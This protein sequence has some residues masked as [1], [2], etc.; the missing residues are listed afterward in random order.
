M[1]EEKEDNGTRSQILRTLKG[2]H[3]KNK[4]IIGFDIETYGRENYFYHGGL[5]DDKDGY[6]L[7]YDKEE[8]IK[9]LFK[10]A[11]KT[12]T[13][14]VTATN[15]MFDFTGLFYGSKYW[16]DFQLVMKQGKMLMAKYKDPN[17]HF[18]LAFIDTLN[19]AQFGVKTMGEILGKPKLE[20][21]ACIKNIRYVKNSEGEIE[22]KP[23]GYAR[24]PRD[25]KEKRE[26]E[27]YNRQD[28]I[29]T[30]EFMLFLQE[31]FKS[32]GGKTKL[33]T[34][35]TA[36]DI[37]RRRHLKKWIF[38]EDLILGR[39][40]NNTIH[41]FIFDSYSGG[42]TEVFK[43]GFVKGRLRV[44]DINSMYSEAMLNP[45]PQPDSVKLTNSQN[46]SLL[47]FEGTSDV[48]IEAPETYYPLLPYKKMNKHGEPEKLL[49]PKGTYR[50]KY[51]HVELREALKYGYKIKKIYKTL[52]YKRSFSPFKSYIEEIYDKKEEYGKTNNP[53]KTVTK[54]LLNGCLAP[55][56]GAT[57]T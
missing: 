23:K 6:K 46:R 25:Q 54:L 51:N 55:E 38:K 5:Y 17:G 28:C 16:N 26:L 50:G 18:T 12:S 34:S 41:N 3:L 35:S 48:L 39:N 27:I 33:T 36:M 22:E 43:R 30:Y 24:K 9:Y 57:P 40:K 8:M 49:F 52:Y 53:L 21:P 31:G 20:T 7:F 19:Y 29:I 14:Q 32:F 47:E 11:R 13:L 2:K 45:M 1:V 44:Y 37:F 10:L 56:K 15:L 4:K 42:R